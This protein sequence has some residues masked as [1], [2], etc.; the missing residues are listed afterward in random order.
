MSTSALRGPPEMVASVGAQS[1]SIVGE[2]WAKGATEALGQAADIEAEVGF[3]P[4]GSD[5]DD[6]W[7]WTSA[8]FTAD[9]GKNDAYSAS[10]SPSSAGTFAY[11]M[12]FKGGDDEHWTYCDTDGTHNGFDPNQVGVLSVQ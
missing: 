4:V 9:T 8:T 3:G 2:V 11:V 1:E 7:T 12:R 6:G 5:P 10:L